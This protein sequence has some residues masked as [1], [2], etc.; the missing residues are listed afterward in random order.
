MSNTLFTP[1][2]IDTFRNCRRAYDMAFGP[3]HSPVTSNSISSICKPFLLKAIANINQGNIT[4]VTQI[5]KFMGEHWPSD[6]LKQNDAVRAFLFVYKSLI[7][8]LSHPYRPHGGISIGINKKARSRVPHIKVYLEDTFD[9]MLWYPGKA[10]LEL[11]DYHLQPLKSFDPSWPSAG[12]L[13]KQFLSGRLKEKWPFK[14]LALTFCQISPQGIKPYSLNLEE[15]IYNAHWPDLLQTLEEMKA[16]VDY[17]PNPG[18][19]C[20]RCRCATQCE[21]MGVME[22]QLYRVA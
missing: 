18:D 13:V 21:A 1:A 14:K 10:K 12:I 8:Y 6:Q 17:A 22:P 20:E 3:S 7:S 11:I 9:F 2:M 4:N 19:L 5:Q 16:P 15:S